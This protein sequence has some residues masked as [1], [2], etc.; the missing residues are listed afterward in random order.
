MSSRLLFIL[1][2]TIALVVFAGVLWFRYTAGSAAVPRVAVGLPGEANATGEVGDMSIEEAGLFTGDRYKATRRN[3]LQNRVAY[4]RLSFSP[5]P[6]SP[7]KIAAKIRPLLKRDVAAA[8]L[9][10]TAADDLAAAAGLVVARAAGLDDASYLRH[11]EDDLKFDLPTNTTPIGYIYQN[12]LNRRPPD[13]TA[14]DVDIGSIFS[15]LSSAAREYRNGAILARDWSLNRDGGYA[16]RVGRPGPGGDA[17]LL[18]PGM[19]EAAMGYWYGSLADGALLF[20]RPTTPPPNDGVW[21]HML[22]IVR[23]EGGDAYPL[24]IR[25]WYDAPAAKWR[26]D[27]VTRRSSIQVGN[28]P[29]L[30]P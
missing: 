14:E 4:L 9:P 18:T 19:G 6:A 17:N 11:L 16:L 15:D 3:H 25:G 2:A 5:I 30:V 26:I 1:F 29:P 8:G 24:E 12:Y 23:A 22:I 20:Y 13:L 21:A 10:A 28:A 7:E 27:L